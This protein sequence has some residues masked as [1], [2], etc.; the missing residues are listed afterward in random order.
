VENLFPVS[1]LYQF[2][3]TNIAPAGVFINVFPSRIRYY[4]CC[5]VPDFI[6]NS[7]FLIFSF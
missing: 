1:I 6:K 7:T 3:N 2:A 4:W 5:F